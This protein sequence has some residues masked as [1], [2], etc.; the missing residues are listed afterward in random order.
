MLTILL[1]I[2]MAASSC[3]PI[4]QKNS[5]NA[6]QGPLLSDLVV[7]PSPRL[8]IAFPGGNPSYYNLVSEGGMGVARLSVPWS[9]HEPEPGVFSWNALDAK[10]V[11][12]QQLG[13]EPF[14]TMESDAP[15]GVEATTKTAK[16]RPPTDLS[17]WKRFVKT[18]VERYDHDGIDDAPGLLRPVRYHQAANEWLSDKNKS[19]GWTGTIDEFIEFM[20]ATYDAVKASYSDAIF[21]MGGIAAVN[22]DVMALSE[23]LGTYIIHYNFDESTGVTITPDDANDPQYQPLY[24]TAYRVLRECR[25]DYADAHLYGPVEFNDARIPLI[26]RKSPKRSILS[27]ECGGPSRDYDDDITPTDHFM[28]AI[29][30]NLD[31]LARGL[32]FGLWFRLGENPSATTWGNVEVP[33]YDMTATPKGGYWAYKLLAAILKDLEKVEK[34]DNGAYMVYRTK[35]A[36]VLVAWR[37]DERSVFSIPST[38]GASRLLRVTD[39]Q[40]GSYTIEAVPGNGVLS[41]GDL[42]VVVSAL[43]P[44]DS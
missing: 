35:N 34:V 20:N 12:L 23:G 32:E 37:T 39:A 41:L 33:L 28:A 6:S 1:V 29:E 38:V 24:E 36:P 3:I 18:L 17:I 11:R 21:V 2:T 16:N 30:L 7:E 40:S 8:G 19:G 22:V 27:S 43:L 4:G 44:G 42:P 15:W 14:L 25:F 31:M 10:V 26:E 13:I 5:D 9:N